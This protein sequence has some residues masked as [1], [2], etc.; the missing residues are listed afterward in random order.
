M[1]R[2]L[3]KLLQG[4]PAARPPAD[5]PAERDFTRDREDRRVGQL[6]DEDRAWEVASQQRKLDA[7]DKETPPPA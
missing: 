6:S 7:R 5:P 1:L 2:R 4:R 3:V